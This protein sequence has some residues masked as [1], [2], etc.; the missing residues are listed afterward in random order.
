MR[1]ELWS[2]I[3]SRQRWL[4]GLLVGA[5][6]FGCSES[7]RAQQFALPEPFA[8]RSARASARVID[9]PRRADLQRPEGFSV[10][11]FA[12]GLPGVRTMRL[13]PNGD[14]FVAQS[15]SGVVKVLRDTNGDGVPDTRRTYIEGLRG[16]FGMAFQDG[17]FKIKDDNL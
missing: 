15:R 13:A 10:E 8:T 1:K 5:V 9:Q 7:V 12:A 17:F 3:G 16:V 2:S 11:V 6:N 4:I 14:L